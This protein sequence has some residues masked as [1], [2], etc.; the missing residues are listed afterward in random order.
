MVKVILGRKL[1]M[2][3]IFRDN[4]LVPVTVIEVGP[5]VVTG[6][7]NSQKDGYTSIQLGFGQRNKIKKPIFGQ[8]H[9]LGKFQVIKEFR[10]PSD[11]AVVDYSIGQVI[12]ADVFKPGDRV[13]ISGVTKGKGF[14]GVVKRHGF[15][16]APR[17]HGQSTKYRHPGSIG[18]TTPQRVIKG[19]RMAGRMGG[20]RMTIRNLEVVDV[21]SEKNLLL[22]KGALPGVR[23]VIVEVRSAELTNLGKV[24]RLSKK[25]SYVSSH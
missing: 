16:D 5:A 2:T 15:R 10:L 25:H 22:V 23:N 17:T 9:K 11:E 8:V 7:K 6:V 4:D 21:D 20:E 19:L 1:G 12:A 18:A 14:Q 24:R 3:Q 13:N